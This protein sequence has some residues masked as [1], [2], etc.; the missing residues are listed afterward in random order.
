MY[1]TTSTRP[2]RQG[3]GIGL[4]AGSPDAG[5]GLRP[6]LCRSD[7]AGQYARL[8]QVGETPPDDF[9][10]DA[11]PVLAS[12]LLPHRALHRL[13]IA[14]RLREP[15]LALAVELA[16]DAVPPE[17]RGADEAFLVE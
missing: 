9:V 3:G 14:R 5:P 13:H 11:K 12:F 17:V 7:P 10:A 16:E 2:P 1:A 4:T 15:V 6:L 8:V